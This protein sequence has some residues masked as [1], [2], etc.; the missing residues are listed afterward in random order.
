MINK[1]SP[2]QNL[3]FIT[4]NQQRFK[5]RQKTKNKYFRYYI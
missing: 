5:N 2:V 4:K 3:C 1:W